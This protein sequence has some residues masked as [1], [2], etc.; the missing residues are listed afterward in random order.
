MRI[1]WIVL[2]SALCLTTSPAQAHP[3]ATQPPAPFA[4]GLVGPEGLAF[5]RDGTLYVGT[6]DGTIRKVASDGSHTLLANV[7][8][9]R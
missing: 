4:S 8:L 1:A 6:N 3:A 5:G 7:S 2:A 9:I